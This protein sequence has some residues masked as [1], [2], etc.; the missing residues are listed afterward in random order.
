MHLVMIVKDEAETIRDTLLS[1]RDLISGWTILDTGSS[2]CTCEIVL[3]TMSQENLAYKHGPPGQIYRETLHPWDFSKARN[4]AL[5]LAGTSP[6]F[7]LFLSGG[8][9]VKGRPFW[10][11]WIESV[12]TDVGL[13]VMIEDG[14]LKYKQVR[15]IRRDG[16][17]PLRYVGATHEVLAGSE[18]I[19]TLAPGIVIVRGPTDPA[20]ARARLEEDR[21]ILEQD[22][23]HDPQD[24]RTLFYLG[25]THERL[26]NKGAADMYYSMRI[27]AG[28]WQEEVFESHMRLAK[29]WGEHL[30]V[31]SALTLGPHRAEPLYFLATMAHDRGQHGPAFHFASRASELPYPHKDKLFVQHEIY[32]WRAHH[33]AAIHAWYI[34][35]DFVRDGYYHARSALTGCPPK[36]PEFNQ[37]KAN[38]QMYKERLGY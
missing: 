22:L 13:N 38:Y 6:G 21:D 30:H 7:N 4:R 10:S 33:L 35:E 15:L 12:H 32:A 31:M 18:N 25:Q 23:E 29:M 26:G 2:D 37:V 34:G 17:A 27:D 11:G 36:H 3:E 9:V 28:G 8:E 1:V 14:D 19:D 16:E 20:K 5:E 24:T